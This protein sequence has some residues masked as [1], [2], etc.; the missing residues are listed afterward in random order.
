MYIYIHTYIYIIHIIHILFPAFKIP[1]SGFRQ[2]PDSRTHP[3]NGC[4]R[5]ATK[6]MWFLVTCVTLGLPMNTDDVIILIAIEFVDFR[7]G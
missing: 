6:K 1:S 7:A 2:S 5:F 3:P 4:F